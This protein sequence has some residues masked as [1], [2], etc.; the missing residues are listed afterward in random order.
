MPGSIENVANHAI[1]QL[2]GS[3]NKT[4]VFLCCLKLASFTGI[5]D[6]YTLQDAILLF[7]IGIR[8]NSI[9]LVTRLHDGCA[10][11]SSDLL[12]TSCSFSDSCCRAF[13]TSSSHCCVYM[14]AACSSSTRY[15]DYTLRLN[16]FKA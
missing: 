6:F 1:W 7:M 11:Q 8:K 5:E 13:V 15:N 2:R 14:Y 12:H 4:P 10:A 16:N 3:L 9:L